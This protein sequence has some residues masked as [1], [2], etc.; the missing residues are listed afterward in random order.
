MLI[1]SVQTQPYSLKLRLLM[2]K[3]ADAL[4]DLTKS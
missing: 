3:I 4:H 2:N 1:V